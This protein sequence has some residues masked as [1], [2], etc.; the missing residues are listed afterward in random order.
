MK[1]EKN[2]IRTSPTISRLS[3]EIYQTLGIPISNFLERQAMKLVFDDDKLKD[4]IWIE[5]KLREYQIKFLKEQK[6]IIDKKIS[7]IDDEIEELKEGMVESVREETSKN[8]QKAQERLMNRVTRQRIPF[9][10]AMEEGRRYN[11][12]KISIDDVIRICD[13]N[14]VT[15]KMVLPL[16]DSNVVKVYFDKKCMKFVK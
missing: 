8:I 5:I 10:K 9:E 14:N 4:E 13:E 12:Q 6:T 1:K 2:S 11:I 7:K 15:P 3:Y 16:I